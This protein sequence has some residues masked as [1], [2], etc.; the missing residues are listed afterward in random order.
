MDNNV[1]KVDLNRVDW[2]SSR[3][4][5][6]SLGEALDRLDDKDESYD[7]TWVGKRR[8]IIEA[9]APINKTLRPDVEASE[10]F[11]NTKNMLIVGD[12][13]DA[14]KLLQESYLNK[15]K[16]I[17]IDPPYN[18]GHDFVYHDN[19]T[20]KKSDYIDSSVDIDGNKLI[21]EDR[22]TENSK[23]NGRFHSDWLSMIYPRLKLA[24][25]LLSDDGVIFISI[26]DNEQ[27]NLKKICDEIFGEDNFIAQ[28]VWKKKAGGA[29]DAAYIATDHEYILAYAKIFD[30]CVFYLDHEGQSSANYNLRDEKGFYSLRRLDQ[31]SL[32][33]A[34]SLDF[35]ITAPDGQVYTIEH[36]D[37]NN[38]R[39][40]WRWSKQTVA[41]RMDE[42]VF[43][44]GHVYTKFYEQP[45]VVPRSLLIEDRFGRTRTGKMDI[46]NEFDGIECFS[47]PKPVNL[48][49]FL[50]DISTTG[51]DIILDFFSGSG[52]LGKAVIDLNAKDGGK[53]NFILCQLDEKTEEGS[54]A[55]K[56]GYKSIDEIAADRIRKTGHNIRNDIDAGFR[57]F[58]IADSNEKSDIRKPLSKIGQS[59]LF[60]EIENIKE[61]RTPLDLLFGII[62]ASA[63]PFS[64]NLEARKINDNTVYLY[65]YF[66]EG[67]G[68]AACFDK[69]ISEE[70]IKEI[71]KLKPLTAAFRDLSFVDSAAKIN[72]SEH[73][74]II[75]PDTKVKVI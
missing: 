52:T 9:G 64:L 65:G 63:L 55:K 39:T 51:N 17:Y 46:K 74:R 34:E 53:R 20:T 72:L 23:A 10:N 25:N 40:R 41:E 62:H 67:S 37:P 61:D 32:G 14:L 6:E 43:Q 48:M 71:A 54:E 50:V 13:L 69:N 66:D 2:K 56:A 29:N 19:F 8:S 38:K 60:D 16:M 33:Y 7:F 59:D 68:L 28:L 70:T 49:K 35:P 22:Y 18:T 73:F 11:D 47:F 27:A 42:L 57:L 24:R 31:S 36:K 30:S 12:N 45:G 3:E 15:I 1:E 4:F 26:D 75:S 5:F 44:K 58:R 21:A